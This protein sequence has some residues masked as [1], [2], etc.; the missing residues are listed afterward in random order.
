MMI[1]TCFCGFTNI[2]NNIVSADEKIEIK[3]KSAYVIDADTKTVIFSKDENRRL[4][5]ASM[6]KIMTL[7]LCFES[8]DNTNTHHKVF[9]TRDTS[10]VVLFA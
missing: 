6:C 9:H 4:P 7:L 10:V 8:I 1:I 3:S 2:T 5:I